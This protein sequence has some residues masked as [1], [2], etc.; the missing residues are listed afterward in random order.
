M[1]TQLISNNL[2]N[3]PIRFTSRELYFWCE[4]NIPMLQKMTAVYSKSILQ[5]RIKIPRVF[6]ASNLLTFLVVTTEN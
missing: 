4:E 5:Y 6:K 3:N 1:L 2:Q